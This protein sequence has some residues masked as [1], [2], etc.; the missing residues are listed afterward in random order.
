MT[1]AFQHA[2][3]EFGGRGIPVIPTHRDRPSVPMV[4]KPASLGIQAARNLAGRQ[5]FEDANAGVWCGARSGLTIIDIDD[6]SQVALDAAIERFGA[7]RIIAQ[8][9]SG[10]W[11]LYYRHDGERRAIRPFGIECH[12]DILGNGLAVVPPSSRLPT[13]SKRG[14]EYRLIHGDFS[15]LERLKPI[16]AVDLPKPTESPQTAAVGHRNTV[17][18]HYMLNAASKG[19]DFD[20]L[21]NMALDFNA[22][23]ADPLSRGEIEKT[24]RSACNYREQGR[25]Y[26]IGGVAG[27]VISSVELDAIGANA[28]ALLL[29]TKLRVVHGAKK[30]P[31]ALAKATAAS[32][33]W[34]LPKFRKARSSLV[35]LGLLA[36]LH[37]GGEGQNDPP[38][39]ALPKGHEIVPQYKE[40]S[41]PLSR[42]SNLEAYQTEVGPLDGPVEFG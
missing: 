30:K 18:F 17:V 14:G 32:I 8:T 22:D 31:F 13:T 23:L 37:A 1:G 24:V 36:C 6:D 2:V 41:L 34:S 4:K 12:L 33:G 42:S 3:S 15:A 26:G 39:Y 7:S 35:E 9:P 20:T 25:L 5:R 38:I 21:S 19:Y 40:H 29:L 11:H 27:T 16:R 10:G 28:D